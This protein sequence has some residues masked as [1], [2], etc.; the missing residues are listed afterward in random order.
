MSRTWKSAGPFLIYQDRLIDGRWL[1]YDVQDAHGNSN[2]PDRIM[3]MPVNGGP[4]APVLTQALDGFRC[5]R[6]PATLCVVSQRTPDRKQVLF[7]AFDP[8][9]RPGQE[10][11]KLDTDPNLEYAWDLSPDGRLIAMVMRLS[12]GS[13]KIHSLA[14]HSVQK[15][16]VKDW[17]ELEDV[18]WQSSGRGL[19]ASTHRGQNSIVL[20]INLEGN[21]RVLWEHP[22]AVRVNVVPSP[23]GRRV[24]MFG[25]VL[26][27]NMWM[28]ENF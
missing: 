23:D 16:S 26:N 10:L 13:I 27:Q 9:K 22:G 20:S 25:Q 19:F 24:A 4:P 15:V 17:N 6:A 2:S 3:R 18:T 21:A 14:D 28:M 5:A 11:A 1:L 7:T 12:E 8:I